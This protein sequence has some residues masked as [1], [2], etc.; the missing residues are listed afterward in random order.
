MAE[1]TALPIASTDKSPAAASEAKAIS[2]IVPVYNEE[3]NIQ[4]AYDELTRTMLAL[5]PRYDYEI[6]F[7]DN[8]SLDN[9][10]AKLAELAAG[11]PRVKVIRF[12]RNFGFNR[13]VLTGYRNAAGDCAIQIDC[14]L[15]DPPSLIPQFISKWELGHDVV[16]GIRRQR[17]E[18]FALTLMRRA[19]YRLIRR[20]SADEL[21]LDAGDFRLVDRSVLDALRWIDD[22]QPYL[23][24][25]ISSLSARQ[26]GVVYDRSKR[27]AGESKFPLLALISLAVDGIIGHT[28]IPLRLATYLGFTVAAGTFALTIFYFVGFAFFGALWPS[29]FTTLTILQLVGISLNCILLGI[30]GEYLGRT[31]LQTRRRPTV[32]IETALNIASQP[33]QLAMANHESSNSG[34][35]TG[36]KVVRGDA[37]HSK[38]D[39][40][41]RGDANH[42]AH[43]E[44]IF[45]TPD[46]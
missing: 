17:H 37:G 11:D 42:L 25:L 15:E 8:H 44:D 20:L 6:L 9:S 16:F 4:R 36:D 31:Y 43:H 10:F 22:A 38:T 19:F 35:R 5:G 1:P 7:T 46:K 24:G 28:T 39:G 14:D 30:M 33:H 41:H 40:P 12:A 27:Q 26:V 32:I 23:R 21:P 45:R 18:S 13:S 29:G 3:D 2:I 34:R